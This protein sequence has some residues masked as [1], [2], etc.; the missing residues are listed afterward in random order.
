[1]KNQMLEQELNQNK[2][3]II[4]KYLE[5]FLKLWTINHLDKR[6]YRQKN[7]ILE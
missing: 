3:N 1:M 7:Q 6:Q 4:N 5:L 2:L